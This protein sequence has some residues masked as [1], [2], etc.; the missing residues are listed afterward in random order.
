MNP[1]KVLLIAAK[2]VGL[3]A[4][5]SS[6]FAATPPPSIGVSPSRLEI[7][8]RNSPTTGSA[9]V[10][11]MSAKPVHIATSLVNFDLDE[12]NNLRELAP[13]RGSLA[14]AM[15]LNPVEFTIPANSSQTVR[16]AIMPERLNGLRE[17]RAMLF[18][19]EQV[20]TTHAAVK[21]NFRLGIPIYAR[22][23]EMRPVAHF[24]DVTFD[25]KQ[26]Q[27]VLDIS[28]T[29][30]VQV[31]PTGFYLW[32]PV[33]EYPSERKALARVADLAQHPA[34][35]M[36]GNTTGGR[37]VTKPVFPGTRRSMLVK[38]TPPT[39]LGEYRLVLHVD[40]GEAQIQRSIKY[41]PTQR[42]IVDSD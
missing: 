34:R 21:L 42:L 16:F 19:S 35:T 17:H 11:N 14:N 3:I 26:H 18:F 4:V 31:N 13:R 22:Y 8:V 12:D 40:A 25:A 20:S 33:S 24:N 30:N 5:A 6:S 38:L 36:P 9:T 7:D 32:W 29:G 15:M 41:L 23:G 28:A 2:F 1:T 37:L 10:L 27:L 39:E